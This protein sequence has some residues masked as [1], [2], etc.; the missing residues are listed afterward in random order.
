MAKVK[1]DFKDA[2]IL[3]KVEEY[4]R[5]GLNDKQIA[6]RFG[7]NENYFCGLKGNI[8]E[9][10]E[11]I[12]KGR[13]PLDYNVENV[14]FKKCVGYKQKVH[15]PF[16]LKEKY[17]DEEGRLCEKERIEIIDVE[18]TVFPEVTAQIF[19]LKNR[20]PKQWNRQ[21]EEENTISKDI[22]HGIDIDSWI[23]DKVK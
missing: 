6:E 20:K 16:K 8:S 11:A 14:L 2:T 10:S 9:L 12:K 21:D 23:K 3:A 7:Y 15:K 13:A 1:H 18:E 17:Y 5:D 22:D 19:W 4:A